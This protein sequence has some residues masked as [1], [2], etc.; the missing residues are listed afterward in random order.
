MLVLELAQTAGH[1]IAS[2]EIADDAP[3]ISSADHGHSADIVVQHLVHRLIKKLIG[4]SDDD[5]AAAGR[6]NRRAVVIV[7][8]EGAHHVA[9]RDDARQLLLLVDDL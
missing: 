5:V 1:E 7:L 4:K 6:G 2:A 9:A 3:G 8:R